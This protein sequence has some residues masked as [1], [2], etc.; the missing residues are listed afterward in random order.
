MVSIDKTLAGKGRR[1]TM[2]RWPLR[3]VRHAGVERLD[4]PDSASCTYC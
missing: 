3:P 2:R 1:A 4:I